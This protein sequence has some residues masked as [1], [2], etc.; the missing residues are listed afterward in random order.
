L[1][2]E[3]KADRLH[4][5][6]ELRK[7]GGKMMRGTTEGEESP[8]GPADSGIGLDRVETIVLEREGREED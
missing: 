8:G 4:S 7:I 2:V 1:T 5:D 3:K 6:P